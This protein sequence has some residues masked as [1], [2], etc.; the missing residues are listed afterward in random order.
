M[1]HEEKIKTYYWRTG[2]RGII[3]HVYK[4]VQNVDRNYLKINEYPWMTFVFNPK[5]QGVC[6]GSLI[7]SRWVLT[8]AHCIM[9]M[10]THSML[11][12]EDLV[13]Y[14]GFHDTTPPAF[15]MGPTEQEPF[16]NV[17]YVTEIFCHPSFDRLFPLDNDVA[18]LY[19][20]MPVDLYTY[21]PVC[22]PEPENV[23]D[24]IPGR[25]AWLVG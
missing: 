17:R 10:T 12:P 3:S 18:L 14:L 22:L 23:T 21:T 19:L 6:G 11:K 24:L 20:Q 7:A 4:R 16:R 9:N 13:V 1:W 15:M 2:N 25:P 8:A 5:V